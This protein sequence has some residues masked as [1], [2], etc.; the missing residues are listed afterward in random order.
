MSEPSIHQLLGLPSDVNRPNAY[1]VFGLALGEADQKVI[2]A[3]IERRILTV[4]QAKSAADADVWMQAVRA[5]QAAQKVL[6]DPEQKAALDAKYGILSEPEAAPAIPAGDTDPL[7]ALLP[8]YHSTPGT[9]PQAQPASVHTPPQSAKQHAQASQPTA[10]M[11]LIGGVPLADHRRARRRRGSGGLLFGSIVMAMLGLIVAGLAFMYFNGGNIQVVKNSD[12][13]QVNSGSAPA[14]SSGLRVASPQAIPKDRRG[15]GIML[16]PADAP[17]RSANPPQM[18]DPVPPT[19]EIPISEMPISDAVVPEMQAADPN[20]MSPSE[21]PVTSTTTTPSPGMNPL[22]VPPPVP[23]EEKMAA[24]ETAI[25]A[26]RQAV[27][28]SDW[29]NMKTLCETA[30]KNAVSDD[31]KQAAETLYQVADLAVHYRSAIQKAMAELVAGNEFK[32]TDSM[33]FLV[34]KS[35][36]E[37]ITL[38]RNKRA[39]SYTIDDLPLSVAQ[40]LAPF[41][42]NASSPEGRAAQAVFQVISPKATA[43]HRAQS[44]DTLRGLPSVEGADPQRLADWIES[45]D[46]P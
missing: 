3:A 14:Q 27:I 29:K 44:I 36:A 6:L 24:G 38:Y 25:A 1:Q 42:L 39:F 35:S 41:G 17:P 21:V 10:A 18:P 12:G 15:D 30:E 31:Q 45:L 23:T 8:R 20:M 4:K 13:F 43:G 40:A 28:A 32:L 7:A 5:V 22:E 16:P 33:T 11:T 26:A 34:Q 46:A 9:G 2:R 37:E 19:T